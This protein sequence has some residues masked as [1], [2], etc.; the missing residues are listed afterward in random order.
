MRVL[1]GATG[2]VCAA[3]KS[4]DGKLHG[5]TWQVRAMWSDRPDA[6]RKQA[7]LNSYL[8]LFDHQVLGPDLS[9]GESLA[10]AILLG[11]EC[12][13]VE[14]SRPLEGLFAIAERL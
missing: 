14:V 3:H 4:A 13:R 8:S 5:H 7:E 6:V 11:L 9:W 10:E 12:E 2:I 1:T